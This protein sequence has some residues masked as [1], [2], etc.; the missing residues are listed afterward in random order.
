MPLAA[1][2]VAFS[3]NLPRSRSVGANPNWAL[4]LVGLGGTLIFEQAQSKSQNPKFKN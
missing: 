3:A 2:L 4:R 1:T